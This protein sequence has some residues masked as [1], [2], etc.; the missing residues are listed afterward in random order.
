MYSFGTAPKSK[1]NLR[2]D[3][4]MPEDRTPEAAGYELVTEVLDESAWP[5]VLA[6]VVEFLRERTVTDVTVEFGFVLTRDLRGE[7]TPEKCTVPLN[8][9]EAL[10]EQGFR[11]GT[12]EWDGGS[13]F[14]FTPVG[15]SMQFMLCND[16]DL[17]FS[18]SDWRLLS[19]L[20]QRLSSEGVKV[21]GSGNLV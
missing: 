13:N 10:M 5:S 6:I 1:P 11:D 16:A 19:Y 4:G 7:K 12:I 9:L 8:D 21:Y 2:Y 3:G 14:H 15:L 18:S 17:H 20:G